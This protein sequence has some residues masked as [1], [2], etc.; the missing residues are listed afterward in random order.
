LST[1]KRF[2]EKENAI[3]RQTSTI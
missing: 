1:M 2:K 3:K